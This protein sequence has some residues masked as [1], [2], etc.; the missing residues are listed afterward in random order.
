MKSE[1]QSFTLPI[2]I[3]DDKTENIPL[4]VLS[5]NNKWN[6][7]YPMQKNDKQQYTKV[8]KNSLS[9]KL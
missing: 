5:L 2:E 1:S 3:P 9:T 7:K 6:N 8:D 4:Y